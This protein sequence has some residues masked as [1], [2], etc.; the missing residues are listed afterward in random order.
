MRLLQV[1]I[2]LVLFAVVVVSLV[3]DNRSFNGAA[4]PQQRDG[5]CLARE[6]LRSKVDAPFALD[7][8]TQ[9]REGGEMVDAIV[10]FEPTQN[11][12]VADL[13]WTLSD[14]S[15]LVD[16]KVDEFLMA[17]SLNAGAT[18][19]RYFTI[20]GTQVA[21][22]ECAVT[23]RGVWNGQPYAVTRRVPGGVG[24]NAAPSMSKVWEAE[25]DSPYIE[26]LME[27]LSEERKAN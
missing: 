17:D 3:M 10:R 13:V 24:A 6:P 16:G 1:A 25:G 12:T 14:G 4:P 18:T 15:G 2:V 26:A 19:V 7:V 23:A 5:H 8:A 20:V 9:A 22:A 27:C 21:L 11:L